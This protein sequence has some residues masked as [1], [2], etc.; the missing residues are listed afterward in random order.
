M[1]AGNANFEVLGETRTFS[2]I[3]G[4]PKA[5]DWIE[6]NHSIRPL[7]LTHEI[8]QHGLNVS[9]VYDESGGGDQTA[10]LPGVLWK[11]NITIPVDMSDYIITSASVSAIVNGSADQNIETPNDTPITGG[12]A[13][14]FDHAFFYILLSDLQDIEAYQIASYRTDLLGDGLVGRTYSDYSTRDFLAD[15]SM[16]PISESDLIFYLNQIFEHDPNNFTITLG[17]EV[18]SEDNY[19]GFE[20]DNWYSLLIKSC[21]FSFTYEKKIDQFTTVSWKQDGDQISDISNDTIIMEQAILN[22]NYKIDNN[23]TD[24]SPNSEIRVFINNN[25]LTE[26]I[27]LTTANSSFQEAKI[28]G[29]DVGSLIPYNTEIN[30]SIQVYIADEFNLD[31]KITISIDDVFL[32]VTYTVTFPDTQTNLHVFFNG[33]NKT[34]NPIFDLPINTDLN[35]TIK[36]PDD[37]G[38]HI[39]GAIVQLSGN[40]TGTLVE[41]LTH[42][43]YTIIIQ[44]GEF[45]LGEINF[46]VIAHRVN[47]EARKITPILTI[48]KIPAENLQLYLNQEDI[49]SNPYYEIAVN[50]LLNITVKYKDMSGNHISGALLQL[51]GE[52]I[53]ENFNESVS[54]EQYSIVINTTIKLGLGEKEVTILAQADE[55]QTKTINPTLKVR[56]ITTMITPVSGSNT[57]DIIPGNS[58]TIKIYINNTDFN[59][60]I[61]G[62]IVT[63]I[64]EYGDGILSDP[65]NNG[66]YEGTIENIPEGTHQINISAVG[67][68]I[69]N[70][71]SFIV[72]ISAHRP[73]ENII[74]FQVLLT[75]GIIASITLGGYVYAYQKVLKFP[76]PVRKVLKFRRT[77]RKTN[78][79]HVDVISRDKAFQKA[80]KVSLGN[81]MKF[82]KTKPPIDQK[83]KEQEFKESMKKTDKQGASPKN[84]KPMG[85]K[86]DLG[87]PSTKQNLLKSHFKGRLRNTWHKLV[88]INVRFK[89]MKLTI[90]IFLLLNVIIFNQVYNTGSIHSSDYEKE[91]KLSLSRKESYTKQWLNKTSFDDPI[92]PT[93][94]PL[95]GDLGDN[96]DLNATTSTGQ[97]NFEVNGTSGLYNDI[98]GVPRVSEGWIPFNN[99][100]F[101]LPDYY[102]TSNMLMANH[103]YKEDSDQSRN[104]PSV[105][106]RKNVTLSI[107]MS[108]Y[109]ITSV[110][111]SANVSGSADINVETQNDDLSTGSTGN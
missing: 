6:F 44:G 91:N 64:W 67:S 71:E 12:Y 2:E 47:Y 77:L 15:T 75:I 55:H 88:N 25:K 46:E 111:I 97:A 23:W 39:S 27:K 72:T 78:G 28:G 61:Q 36:Y 94:F 8:N 24:S 54:L 16:V 45:N 60:L 69:Y 41:D 20:L 79:P 58:V 107:N 95:F 105:H 51:I 90:L 30:I 106:W 50:K 11:R 86:D 38:D 43:Q 32:N 65:D 92:S 83:Y 35:I 34:S 96:T 93:W 87:R 17:I 103:T 84:D 74:L 109:I 5:Q 62:A 13:S 52:G 85:K 53:L 3:S 70:F 21:N 9:H 81:S 18:D 4:T 29:Y 26:T 48:S 66:I 19:P 1:S 99:S 33:I 40:L 108:D 100:Y 37:I 59:T 102:E 57:F 14:L 98:S 31:K 110:T 63:Y 89:G 49:T 76:K 42:E 7:P 56:E 73:A 104:R 82:L 101:I 10:N 80:Y 68:D 22:F